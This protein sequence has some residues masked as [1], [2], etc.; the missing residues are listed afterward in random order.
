MILETILG[1]GATTLVY[2]KLTKE[3]REKLRFKQ[4]IRD[5]WSV[6]MDGI[7]SR[8]ENKVD[9]QYEIEDII[10]KH[11]GFDAIISI[12]YGKNLKEFRR[13]IPSIEVAY[14]GNV[15]VEYATDK[16]SMYM[17]FHIHGYPLSDSD[18]IKFRWYS[19]FQDEN[20]FRN[21]SGETYKL[22]NASKIFHPSNKD[23]LIGYRYTIDIPSG[24]N[25][26]TLESYSLE[27]NK[28]FPICT[29]RYDRETNET[30]AEILLKKLG[31]NEPYKLVKCKPYEWYVG[32]THAYK[33]II[34]NF[35]D[36]PN[37][38]WGGKAGTGKTVSLIGGL[39]N[40]CLQHTPNDFN[41]F[42]CML[43]DKQD[44]RVFKKTTFCKYYA[45]NLDKAHRMLLYLSDECS[46][47]NRLFDSQR[48]LIVNVY[49]YNKNFPQFALPLLY[50][51]IDEIASFSLNG[52]E[53]NRAEKDTKEKCS[54]LMWKLAREGRSAGIY[55][56]LSTQ[57]GDLKNLDANV[58][59]NLGNQVCFYLP[60]ISSAMTILGNGDTATACTKLRK[61]REFIANSDEVYVGK[62]L[63]LATT[64]MAELL[65][66][67]YEKDKQFLELDKHGKI[68]TDDVPPKETDVK[69]L[70]SDD[71]KVSTAK[72]PPRWG[73]LGNKNQK[74]G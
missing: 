50:L 59:G 46:R 71:T 56:C 3:V 70:D 72:K 51:C 74:K 60:N 54:A 39:I 2:K 44:L 17:R 67:Y 58:K 10:K 49:E 19:A 61:Q 41:I 28:I 20:R 38:I 12:P 18:N 7:G 23:E 16:T 24:L 40:L 21:I 29:I 64:K 4:D 43:S 42:V 69:E 48:K 13:L 22:T 35:K 32:M 14:R 8:T 55:T 9:Q 34:L 65:E 45:D 33:P 37:C 26:E 62:T 6:L 5:K 15:I 73:Q 30:V 36:D 52:T 31:D 57:R 63:N 66:P 47:R 68:K 1:I 25:Y 27:L 53:M 11:Y